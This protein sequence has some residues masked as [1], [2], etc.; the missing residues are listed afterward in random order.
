MRVYDERGRL[1][2]TGSGGSSSSDSD[3]VGTLLVNGEVTTPVQDF[4]AR[5]LLEQIF[6]LL[7]EIRDE[8][9]ERR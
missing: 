8:L 9:K 7:M 2:T 1:L 5:I 3:V 4:N 6:L